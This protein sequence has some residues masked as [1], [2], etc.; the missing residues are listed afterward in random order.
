MSRKI[1]L[2]IPGGSRCPASASYQDQLRNMLNNLS[3]HPLLKLEESPS[4]SSTRSGP[5]YCVI[6]PTEVGQNWQI[7]E[8]FP[9]DSTKELT[10]YDFPCISET[11]Q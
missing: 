6:V 7:S 4:I 8:Y 5:I 10:H 9:G 2:Q 1:M 3:A 11:L